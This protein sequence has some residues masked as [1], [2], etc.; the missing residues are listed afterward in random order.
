M[1]PASSEHGRTSLM[2]N[3]LRLPTI[4]RLWAEFAARSDQE[5]WPASR[6]LGGLLEHELA[7]RAKR[8]LERH[9]VESQ[10]DASK[11]LACWRCREIRWSDLLARKF[12]CL[13]HPPYS[14]PR[15][16]LNGRAL[17]YQ[18]RGCRFD[19]HNAHQH[20]GSS[21]ALATAGGCNPP[22]SRNTSFDSKMIHEYRIYSYL[23]RIVSVEGDSSGSLVSTMDLKSTSGQLLSNAVNPVSNRVRHP[24]PRELASAHA[25]FRDSGLTS[26]RHE[27]SAAAWTMSFI[28]FA[29]C[30]CGRSPKTISLCTAYRSGLGMLTTTGPNLSSTTVVMGDS[31][32]NSMNGNGCKETLSNA[33]KIGS[34]PSR[35][36][37][38]RKSRSKS[39]SSAFRNVVPVILGTKPMFKDSMAFLVL[40]ETVAGSATEM[41]L[42][43]CAK[44]KSTVA[45][46]DDQIR[47]K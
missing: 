9:R 6:F 13:P 36:R 12:Q 20:L 44:S 24:R 45:L 26:E 46:P 32:E 11:T 16:K 14:F 15:G 23:L 42:P 30:P 41:F 47:P 17:V 43:A 38:V 21:A 25:S 28:D 5:G 39:G 35:E 40:V 19:V 18:I 29:L 31:M 22:S 8:R 33:E 4:G 10:L 1:T 34:S 3:E 7:E 27:K 37:E 2:L